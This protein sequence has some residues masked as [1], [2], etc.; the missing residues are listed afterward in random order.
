MRCEWLQS[1]AMSPLCSTYA[2][3]LW[4]EVWILPRRTMMRCEWLQSVAMWP[5]CSTYASFLWSEA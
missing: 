5:L 2:S 3:F 4:S 1:V